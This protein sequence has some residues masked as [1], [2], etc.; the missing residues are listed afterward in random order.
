MRIREVQ[1]Y[2]IFGADFP[3]INVKRFLSSICWLFDKPML[4]YMDLVLR[5]HIYMK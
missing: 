1:L 4:C 3:S 5:K 2:F